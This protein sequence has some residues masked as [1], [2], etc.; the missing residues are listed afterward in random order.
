MLW[1]LCSCCPQLCCDYVV[2]ASALA[3][4]VVAFDVV[5]C[6]LRISSDGGSS[7]SKEKV[8]KVEV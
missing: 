3:V 5:L 2:V 1:M 4:A 6:S 8:S 7:E